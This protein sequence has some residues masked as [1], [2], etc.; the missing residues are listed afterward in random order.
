MAERNQFG[1][2]LYDASPG[3]DGDCGE[4][5]L[6]DRTLTE[7][8]DDKNIT[9]ADRITTDDGVHIIFQYHFLRFFAT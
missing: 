5:C 3:R 7:Q 8:P 9:I 1:G 6:E 2:N 4:M